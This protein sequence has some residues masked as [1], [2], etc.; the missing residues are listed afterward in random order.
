[1]LALQ[2]ESGGSFLPAE[3]VSVEGCI[4]GWHA[5]Y[6]TLLHAGALAYSIGRVMLKETPEATAAKAVSWSI[7][8]Q[9]DDALVSA[10]SDMFMTSVGT[11]PRSVQ[12]G[13]LPTKEQVE[14]AVRAVQLEL[15]EVVYPGPGLGAEISDLKSTL[16]G[17]LSV[18]L[19]NLWLRGTYIAKGNATM[20]RG[21]VKLSHQAFSI[22]EHS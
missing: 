1:M 14:T 2:I 6:D 22:S 4:M 16:S 8:S 12:N 21:G 7:S 11:Y 3:G 15:R 13:V 19:N 10:T 5:A 18:F 9:I 17:D 20:W